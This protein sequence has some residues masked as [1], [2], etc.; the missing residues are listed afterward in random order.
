MAARRSTRATLFVLGAMKVRITG[1]HWA[2]SGL[3][4]LVVGGVAAA[5]AYGVGFVLSH[6]GISQQ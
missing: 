6:L 3:E 4:T 1:R 5:A 2:K